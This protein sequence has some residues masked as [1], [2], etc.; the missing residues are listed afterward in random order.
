MKTP[1]PA[2]PLDQVEHLAEALREQGA[3]EEQIPELSKSLIRLNDWEVSSPTHADEQKLVER[4]LPF[5]SEH[6]PYPQYFTS[7]FERPNF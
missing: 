3:T 1:T 6:I 4:L 5:C 2:W 7:S